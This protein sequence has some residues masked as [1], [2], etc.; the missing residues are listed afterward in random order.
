MAAEGEPGSLVQDLTVTDNVVTAGAPHSSNTIT[1]AGLAT[2]IRVERRQR[3]IFSNNSTTVPGRG[4]ALFFAH[5]DGLT[6]SGNTQPLLGGSIAWFRDCS[7][8]SF[9]G[10]G[11]SS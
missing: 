7:S 4:P 8:V 2:S 10:V 9:D 5:I 6:V 3:V 1:D 11:P